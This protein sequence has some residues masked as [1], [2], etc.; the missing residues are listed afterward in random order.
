MNDIQ[1][2]PHYKVRY[3]NAKGEVKDHEI[4][5]PFDPV[6][7]KGEEVGFTAYSYGKGIRSFRRDRILNMQKTS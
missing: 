3:R 4:G 5:Q 2:L 1:E 7:N 6:F